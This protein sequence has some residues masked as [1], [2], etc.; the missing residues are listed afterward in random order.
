MNPT[1]AAG[2]AELAAGGL[3]LI[4]DIVQRLKAASSQVSYIDVA[5]PARVEPVLLVD[6]DCMNLPYLPD[7][8]QTMQSLFTGYYLQAV[9]ML[10]S[11][12]KISVMGKLGQLN[13]N[14]NEDP[15]WVKQ[16]LNT[17]SRGFESR[18]DPNARMNIE[19]Y[20]FKLP[21]SVKKLGI[22]STFSEV[23]QKA[24][25]VKETNIG[26]QKIQEG[27]GGSVSSGGKNGNN[28]DLSENV[29]LSIGRM[30]EVS[31]TEDGKTACVKVS[32][33]LLA[34]I[35]PTSVLSTIFTTTNA[36]DASYGKRW[37]KLME[38]QISF[39]NDFVLHKD[40]MAKRR[41]T[42]ISDKSGVYREIL[43]RQGA[44]YRAGLISKRPSLGQASNLCIMSL[45]TL[46]AIEY[47]MG[48]KITQSRVRDE[49]FNETS[50]MIIAVID[51]GYERVKFYHRGIPIASDFSISEIKSTNKGSGPDVMEIMKTLVSGSAPTL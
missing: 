36:D 46:E 43:Q 5:R 29:P 16:A 10:T 26:P 25:S 33:R 3:D 14:R 7:V 15:Y 45:D 34:S 17:L 23:L 30:Y 37:E 31:M 39:W 12:G 20:K 47:K 13:P 50:M 1:L 6:A 40:L 51:A 38:G 49:L 11:V 44:H 42:L 19:Q 28:I 22:E 8:T 32:I 21:M 41:K 24:E 2:S 18:L 4:V 35:T 48:G 9:S 27:L